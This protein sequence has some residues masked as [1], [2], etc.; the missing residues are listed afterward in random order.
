MA[1]QE[2]FICFAWENQRYQLP[3][4]SVEG[5]EIVVVHPGYRNADAG[6]DYTQSHIRIDGV[7]WHGDVEVHLKSSDWWHHGHQND[8]R[9]RNLVLHVVYQDDRPQRLNHN[10]LAT[11]SLQEQLMPG[12]MD[13]YQQF[14]LNSDWIP[15]SAHLGK[16][17]VFSRSVWIQRMAVERME[18]KAG[19]VLQEVAQNQGD[20]HQALFTQLGRSLAGPI[21]AEAFSSIGRQVPVR[22]LDRYRSPEG[23]AL[24]ALLLGQA[25]LLNKPHSEEPHLQKLQSEYTFL[26]EK[27]QLEPQA[28]T[29]LKYAKMRPGNFPDLR[30]V[31]WASIWNAH[32]G[33]F[34]ELLSCH[35]VA[36]M[37]RCFT[38]GTIDPYWKK[39][40][41]LGD[42]PGA[43][44]T[45]VPGKNTLS[46]LLINVAI[47]FFYAYGQ[48]IDDLR[49]KAH[50]LD[51]MTQLKPESNRFIRK[52]QEN[53]IKPR[54]A[55]DT[56]GLYHL[57]HQYCRPK[58]CLRCS[59][60]KM[61]MNGELN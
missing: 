19:R 15:C 51:L 43:L 36:Q 3:L 5:K 46:H 22:M 29:L 32:P 8:D 26:K 39:H 52:W 56:Q 30:L 14:Q 42:E 47:P 16:V 33:L 24:E 61:V 2:E 40:W 59:I 38:P 27:H 45:A 18:D 31:Q 28:T 17:H 10:A 12:L 6:P 1:M 23:L 55:S 9:Y 7:S 21:N 49:I 48:S 4:I 58:R 37:F 57:Y 11:V 34:Q 53:G 25:G 20:W 44:H 13:L 50:A 60:G 41:R 35:D 54:N